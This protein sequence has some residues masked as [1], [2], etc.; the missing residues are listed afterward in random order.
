MRKPRTPR[1]RSIAKT[2]RKFKYKRL[3]SGQG[4]N[5]G[6]PP[7]GRIVIRRRQAIAIALSIAG[8]KYGPYVPKTDRGWKNTALH[9]R[10]HGKFGGS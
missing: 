6:L 4:K 2:M 10:A 8:R 3:H 9:A 7:S 5:K 1:E